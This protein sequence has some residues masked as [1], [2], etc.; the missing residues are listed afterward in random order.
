MNTRSQT[1][2]CIPKLSRLVSKDHL[3][4]SLHTVMQAAEEPSSHFK[5]G[6]RPESDDDA[7][8]P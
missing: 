2:E 8:G 5:V 4:E 6:L 1:A 3:L 7:L